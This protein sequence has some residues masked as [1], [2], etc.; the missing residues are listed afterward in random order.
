[1]PFGQKNADATYQCAMRRIFDDMLYKNVECYVDDL[2][3]KSK[4][5]KQPPMRSLHGVSHIK[6]EILDN[7]LDEDIFYVD[8]FPLWMMSFDGSAYYDG[9]GEEEVNQVLEEAH[10]EICG[11]HQSRPKLHF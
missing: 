4:E 6:K 3:M 8:V 1:M 2:V 11:A 9:T 7:L 5:K 10:S